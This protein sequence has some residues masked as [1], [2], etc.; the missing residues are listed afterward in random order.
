MGKVNDGVFAD[1]ESKVL[2]YKN[3]FQ[4][5]EEDERV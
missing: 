2:N 3:A 5:K 4:L 1:T